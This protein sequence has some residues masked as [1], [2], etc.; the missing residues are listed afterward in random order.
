MKMQHKCD[1]Y[2]RLGEN[3]D[4]LTLNHLPTDSKSPSLLH[5]CAFSIQKPS[6]FYLK[7]AFS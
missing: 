1:N 5:K 6:T 2:S 7:L 4:T 3:K